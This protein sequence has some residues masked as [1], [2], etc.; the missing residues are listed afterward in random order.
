M[1]LILTLTLLTT[2]L[3]SCAKNEAGPF[4]EPNNGCD[5]TD[6]SFNVEIAP[7]LQQNCVSCHN[8]PQNNGDFT[9]YTTVKALADSGILW[10]RVG[11]QKDM[12]PTGPL[13]GCTLE[14]IEAWI[15]SGAPEN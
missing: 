9:D 2:L 1:K 13:V 15:N 11:V 12:P 6:L 7:I 3:I 4:V 5:T 14:Q 8:S 10:Q